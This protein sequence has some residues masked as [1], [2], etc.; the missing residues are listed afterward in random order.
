MKEEDKV[1]SPREIYE[2]LDKTLTNSPDTYFVA[3]LMAHLQMMHLHI[4]AI[5]CHCECLG[6][7][8]ENSLAVCRN[9]T[10]PYSNSTYYNVLRKWDMVDE[11]GNPKI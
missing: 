9:E 1:Q 10:P 7:N 8:A 5:A 4:R 11:E 2:E 3:V 6:M